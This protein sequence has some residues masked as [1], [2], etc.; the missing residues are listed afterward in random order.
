MTGFKICAVLVLVVH[1]AFILWLI[2]GYL[3][4]RNNRVLRWF[5]VVCLI[6]GVVIEIVPWPCPLTLLETWCEGRAGIVPYRQP[7]LVHYLEALIYPDIPD[8]LLIAGASIVC[9]MNAVL[10]LHRFKKG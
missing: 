9:L 3:V 7:F 6:Y 8:S 4:A 5:H 2:F 10:Y 1:L